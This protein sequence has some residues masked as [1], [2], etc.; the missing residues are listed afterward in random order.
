MLLLMHPLHPSMGRFGSSCC[1]ATAEVRIREGAWKKFKLARNN[2]NGKR[3][4]MR[5]EQNRIL[6][7]KLKKTSCAE[8]LQLKKI[9]FPEGAQF[10][11]KTWQK[12]QTIFRLCVAKPFPVFVW[13]LWGTLWALDGKMERGLLQKTETRECPCSLHYKVYNLIKKTES[14]F[15]SPHC[16]PPWPTRQLT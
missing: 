13:A 5:L 9:H 7:S 12:D 1:A 4:E 2:H 11:P 6:L 10:A 15:H 8:G 16:T 14:Q 3:L